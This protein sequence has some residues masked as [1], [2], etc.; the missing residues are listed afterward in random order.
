[1][2]SLLPLLLLPSLVFAA[3]LRSARDSN[4]EAAIDDYARAYIDAG[5]LAGQLVV[6]RDGTVIAERNW[7]MANRET[8]TPIDADT[9][10]NIASITKPMTW[11]VAHMLID[12]GKMSESDS[13]EQLFSP[14]S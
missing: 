10:I 2:R 8:E 5:H 12:E 4:L 7:G 14:S 13:V 3:P 11:T 6:A 9:R 1:M